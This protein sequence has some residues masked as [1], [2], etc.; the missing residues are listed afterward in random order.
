MPWLPPF[1]ASLKFWGSEHPDIVLTGIELLISSHFA[2]LYARN[3]MRGLEIVAD[4]TITKVEPA[5]MAHGL[6]KYYVARVPLSRTTFDDVASG[7]EYEE[8]WTCQECRQAENLLRFKRVAI[9]PGS[10]TGEDI[11]IARGLP[12]VVITSGRFADFCRANTFNNV[13]L[14]EASKYAIDWE[15]LE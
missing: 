7:A 13:L 10:W 1:R 8:P 12:G 4:V 11:F 15:P 14:V 5:R 6:P 9:V 2:D 3:G